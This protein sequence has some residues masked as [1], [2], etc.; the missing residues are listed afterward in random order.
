MESPNIYI[1][2][3]GHP[4]KEIRERS[5]K[6]LLTK[7]Q[8]GWVLPDEIDI[9]RELVNNLLNWL[10]ENHPLQKEVLQLL[11]ITLKTKNGAYIVKDQGVSTILTHLNSLKSNT[12]AIDVLEDIIETLR[13]I[14]TVDSECSL[15]IPPLQLNSSSSSKTSRN[16]S[17]C[18]G[19]NN[20]CQEKIYCFVGNDGE[21]YKNQKTD[22]KNSG[23]KCLLF[24]WVDLGPSDI[25][26]MNLIMDS[27]KVSKSTR[28]C[29]RFIR[30]VFLRDF[31]VQIFL[32]R[33]TIVKTLL[34]ISSGQCGGNP[35][36]A[37]CVLL[38][39]TRA[40]HMQFMQLLSLDFVCKSQKVSENKEDMEDNINLELQKAIDYRQDSPHQ[41]ALLALRQQPVP[42]FALDA[43]QTIFTVMAR[44]VVDESTIEDLDLKQINTC[45]SLVDSMLKL[46]LD[47]VTKKFWR[48]EHSTK[49]HRDIA[50]KSCI[51]M[52]MLGDLLTK[53]NKAFEKNPEG[54][55]YRIVWLRLVQCG[56]QL[57]QWAK[58]S[59]LPP[60]TLV[61][62]LQMA[63]IDPVL[64]LLYPKI[65]YQINNV[66]SVAKSSLDKEHKSK[67]CE[68]T[69]VYTSIECAVKF[70]TIKFKESRND[71]E[72]LIS[73]QKTLPIFHFNLD[74]KYFKEVVSVLFETA[75]NLDQNDINWCMECEIAL[76]LMAHGVEWIK[77]TFYMLLTEFIRNAFVGDESKQTENEKCLKLMCHVEILTEICCQGLSS[78]IEEVEASSSEIMLL[79]LRGRLVLSEGCWWQ[80]LATV[81]AVFPLLHVYAAH[82]TVLGKA[83]CKSLEMEISMCMGV[84]RAERRRGLARALYVHCGAVRV[85]AARQLCHEL[86]DKKYLPPSE[87]VRADVLLNAMKRVEPQDFNLED[88]AMQSSQTTGL[89][90][91][92]E[93]LKQD[94]TLETDGLTYSAREG[95][96]KATL[97]PALRRSTLQQL[98]VMMRNRG[99]HEVFMKN[100]GLN[101]IVSLLRMSLMVDDFLTYPECAISCVSILNSIG[102]ESR[103]T[104]A[105]IQ[106]LPLLLLRV[107]L[108]FPAND[109]CV[110]LCTQV[111]A[112][113]IWAGFVLHEI[114]AQGH[115]APAAPL[116]VV[117]RTRLP[118]PALSYW[119][120]SPNTE[121]SRIDW[122]L[123]D[124]TW[125]NA[126]VFRWW[127]ANGGAAGVRA[128]LVSE[129]NEYFA[130]NVSA[131][132]P[133]LT[134][135]ASCL[136]AVCT[137][138]LLALENATSH[139]QV[140]QALLLLQSC[141]PLT[142]VSRAPRELC[143]LPW[144]HTARFLRAPPASP[145]DV[146]LL[147][148][149]LHC[150]LAYMT[151]VSA[152]DNSM[153]WIKELFI[154]NDA[155]IIALLSRDQMYPH[156]TQDDIELT[157]LRILIVRV[158]VRSIEIVQQDGDYSSNKM[159]SLI[160][161]LLASLEMIDLKNFHMLGYLNELLRCTRYAV[162]SRYCVLSEDTL[163]HALR[164]M[165]RTLGGCASGCGRKGHACRL[166]A[167]LATLALVTHAHKQNIPVQRWSECFCAATMRVLV[168]DC[169]ASRTE[170]RAAALRT[171]AAIA[172]HA[173]LLPHLVQ[174]LPCESLLEF[175]VGAFSRS[176]EA[177]AV[178][179]AAA[180]VITTVTVR[181]STAQISE[182]DVMKTIIETSFI[183]ECLNILIDFC[184]K[185]DYDEFI[186]PNVPL[187]V[188]ERESELDVRA[189]KC[190][191]AFSPS[192]RHRKAPP[193]APLVAAIA[194]VINN[195][196]TYKHADVKR[197]NEQGLYRILFRCACWTSE[198]PS[199]SS[200][201]RV[202]ACRALVVAA[203]HRC[204]RAALA[205]TVDCLH[206]FTDN[207]ILCSQIND[208]CD[209]ELSAVTQSYLLLASLLQEEPAKDTIWKE[210]KSEK[211]TLFFHLLLESLEN[212]NAELCDAAI[213]CLSVLTS[214]MAK[215]TQK[216]MS[217]DER[218]IKF[219]DNIKSEILTDRLSAGDGQDLEDCQPE[220]V[221]ESYCK[222]LVKL[223]H[224]Y[225]DSNPCYC[226]HDER[227]CR[228]CACLASLLRA[229]V[230]ARAYGTH[231]R[232]PRA[233]AT[234]LQ[235]IRD[236]LSLQ[237]KS[238]E[239]IR[240]SNS[241]PILETLHWLLTLMSCLMIDSPAVKESL[242][243]EHIEIS[244][245]RL[246]PWCMMT[247]T[248]RTDLL[249]L[250][251]N[252]TNNCPKAW[253]R[254]CVC[255]SGRS[256]LGEACALAVREAARVRAPALLAAVYRVLTNC[257]SNHHCR[258]V[259][260]KSELVSSAVRSCVR[261]SAAAGLCAALARY[262]DGAGAVAGALPPAPPRR[263][264]PALAHAAHHARQLC[265]QSQD[266]LELFSSALLAG[267]TSEVVTAAR[268]IWA[269]AANNHRA[270]LILRTNGLA[271]AVESGLQRLA[272][273]TN[274]EAERAVQL[275]QYTH[276]VL[277]TS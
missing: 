233:L 107:I 71:E 13:F 168:A 247:E 92:L 2:K 178:R 215:S 12:D 264:L 98:A 90:Q 105:S 142:C 159:E 163:I 176:D 16:G 151:H 175:A 246:W 184:N 50:H 97:E 141:L 138:S 43:L 85:D 44:S 244:L 207:L 80:L 108:I 87:S 113:C 106:D 33:P 6:L 60:A 238:A 167:T 189:E 3:L 263:L 216:D 147:N 28:R 114:D 166:D 42:I 102:F 10:N 190:D 117:R 137:Q 156:S 181:S 9:I 46:L 177:N 35:Q 38:C 20:E 96:S 248:L 212:S 210:L 99:M 155:S 110:L 63:Q 77:T 164:A 251:V 192:S 53:Y 1:K 256:V 127:W 170:L 171:V 65:S 79:I 30:D 144:R 72:L 194:D 257:T 54:V 152:R 273:L 271:S 182:N 214:S 49:T 22:I 245:V 228:V 61:T 129:A 100:N 272:K 209:M 103:H 183:E 34:A 37:L 86:D 8:C 225:S 224:E 4:I 269:L 52:R 123:S 270:K 29:C 148:T 135:S 249:L 185:E 7:L 40:L 187:S 88:S 27:L 19:F 125:R 25:K 218:T 116:S 120:T 255:V 236:A 234:A 145:A 130:P 59:P 133:A 57:L 66:L 169:G 252:F 131:P 204:V 5:L 232:L 45:L 83:I 109:S 23:I 221:V 69:K 191:V 180:A 219:F 265:L 153:T 18:N 111:L 15:R 31:P 160:K 122:L 47:C 162:Y 195:I 149:L 260:I 68:L 174:C 217:K 140:I 202:A 199:E 253:S 250:L 258:S 62:A 237:G 268:A 229:S 128:G 241:D 73:I 231:R 275:L 14:N 172:T 261:S 205:N 203:T 95:L 39:I 55:Y 243:D 239:V 93:V 146:H 82:D 124:E 119:N 139:Q 75:K 230:R 266:I 64:D 226:S 91:I 277:Q 254:L 193:T 197:W 179:A 134:A 165:T 11:L 200:G 81:Q 70:K 67:F 240:N 186:E 132:G 126:V 276:T 78:N 196:S 32:N 17:S 112:L 115:R 76:K 211:S 154:G 262:A 56:G 208:K 41:D 220:Y 173:Q 242:C 206:E 121:H 213:Y 84:S 48:V 89:E 143:G 118:F 94:L 101:L 51:V 222:I 198:D 274:G 161:I 24:P 223:F 26:T 150:V 104:L 58:D 21:T 235:R 136:T 157:Q 201:V 259:M 267:D 227:W 188:L 158:L 36:E 74:K